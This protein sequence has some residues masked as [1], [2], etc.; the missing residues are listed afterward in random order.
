MQISGCM[1][2]Y[3][4]GKPIALDHEGDSC[5]Q[6]LHR[7]TKLES[8]CRSPNVYFEADIA[9]NLEAELA[10]SKRIKCPAVD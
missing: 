3:V 10:R 9:V 1:T 4:K 6:E 2:H 8:V 5:T 7:V